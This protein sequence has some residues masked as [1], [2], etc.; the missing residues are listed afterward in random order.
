MFDELAISFI[1]ALLIVVITH[2]FLKKLFK[3]DWRRIV[4]V[5]IIGY[6]LM[7]YPNKAISTYLYDWVTENTYP[8]KWVLTMEGYL[9][10]VL[11]ILVPAIY[12]EFM[13]VK[14]RII[15]TLIALAPLEIV[16]MVIIVLIVIKQI[17]N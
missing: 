17:E 11:F 6:F 1:S 7:L 14:R 9:L 12:A 10:I 4:L 13:K 16:L 15:S 2:P 8:P 3:Q 5:Q